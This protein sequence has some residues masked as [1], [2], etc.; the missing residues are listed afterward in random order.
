M[1]SSR[2]PLLLAIG[3]AIGLMAGTFLVDVFG[4]AERDGWDY[5]ISGV[6][7]LVVGFPVALL[8]ERSRGAS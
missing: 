7:G 1:F 8:R 6:V 2:R 5:L 3:V 4:W